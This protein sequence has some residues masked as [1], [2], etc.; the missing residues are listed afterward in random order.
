[1]IDRDDRTD[2]EI[3]IN[4]DKNII[5]LSKRHIKSYLLDDE[6]I[7]KFI[8]INNQDKYTEIQS[9]IKMLLQIVLIEEIQKMI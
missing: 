8:Y 7:K 1:M 5:V 2:E 9:L 4:E 3:K 6:I